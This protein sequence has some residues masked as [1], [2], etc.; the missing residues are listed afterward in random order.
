MLLACTASPTNR[1]KCAGFDYAVISVPTPLK[2]GVPD[3]SYIEDASTQLARFVRPGSTVVLESSTYPGTTEEVVGPILEDGSGLTAGED[4]FLGYSP[5]RVDPGNCTWTLVN[6]PKIVSGINA[7]SLTRIDRFYRRLVERTVPV[8]RPAEAE[9]A[10]LL[11]NTFRHVNIALVNETAMFAHEL[12]IDIWDALDAAATK[13]F[14]YMRFNPGPGVGG[15]CLPV[16]PSYLSWRCRYTLGRPSRFIELANDINTG[17][18]TYV[19]N[20]L[21][22][23]LNE[24]SLC[25]KDRNI[26]LLGL[27]Y[28]KNTGDARESPARTIASQLVVARRQ[29]QRRGSLPPRGRR[30]RRR[31]LGRPHRRPSWPGRTRSCC[32]STTTSSTS[33]RSPSTA[34]SST[35]VGSSPVP[36]SKSCESLG[37]TRRTA[38]TPRSTSCTAA[39]PC[40]STRGSR[41]RV[42]SSGRGAS[43]PTTAISTWTR[44]AAATSCSSP[45]ITRTTSTS[46]SCGRCQPA[47]VVVVPRYRHTSLVDTLRRE[48]PN[49]VITIED[50]EPFELGQGL[51]VTPV[52]QSV[53][54]WD[55]CAFI[56]QSPTETILDLNDL[57]I[58][59]VD[60]AWVAANFRID[61]LLLQYSGANWHP[62][63]YS[64]PEAKKRALARRK[65][66]TKYRHVADVVHALDPA[67]VVPCAGPPCFLDDELFDL[68]FSEHSIFPGAD[69]F[70]R[71]AASEGFAER[72]RVLMPGDELVPGRRGQELTER[73]LT[74]PPYSDKRRYLEAYRER[75]RPALQDH[76]AAIPEPDGPL[77]ERFVD[78][79]RPL[80]L[81]NP[82]LAERIGGGFLIETTDDDEQI[83]V[84]FGDRTAPVRRY[85][86][87]SWIYRLRSERRFLNEIVERRLRW[88]EL[89]LSM[90]VE[91]T[92]VPDV[93]NE[94]LTVF[95]RFADA[96]QYEVFETYERTRVANDWF[97]LEHRGRDAHGAADVPPR[98]GRPLEG[99][100]R[101]RLHRVSGARVAV[102]AARRHVLA[103]R[104]IRSTSRRSPMNTQQPP[105]GARS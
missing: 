37:C 55:D 86:D 64:Y 33:A 82:Y 93:Y 47:T 26:L 2:D 29:R 35:V 79:F 71:F 39:C 22:L 75:R 34:S 105:E 67:I 27:S 62:H 68:N 78:Y 42:R 49:R 76:L 30:A 3:L 46:T 74:L 90:R 4:F 56:I 83:F 15:H 88:E 11:E 6:T 50:R 60:L 69:D 41:P 9:L 23:A 102:L 7:A 19:V 51:T 1:E 5:E 18:P 99:Q 73:N 40:S 59:Q 13:P 80:V 77:L 104:D 48:L 72:V 85:V 95:L 20:R 17:M 21:V 24:R 66:F 43:S 65:I 10:K 84:D 61:T 8:S 100:D 52:L 92:R 45:T 96:R 16:D 14:G 31:P 57:K 54:I 94:P 32:S 36:T 81:A 87:D 97:P 53:P 103:H 25:V 58:P 63:V 44:C 91:L 101:G 38:D 28:K 70:Y 98:R 12:G 89:L